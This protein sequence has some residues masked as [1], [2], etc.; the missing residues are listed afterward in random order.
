MR[1]TVTAECYS[2]GLWRNRGIRRMLAAT[3]VQ[4][5]LPG[6]G[7]A[8]AVWGANGRASAR[9]MRAAMR[10]G[11]PL[12]WLEDAPL[13]SVYPNDPLPIGVWVDHQR[14][15][16]DAS[17]P[18]DLED[19]L[20]AA[21]VPSEAAEHLCA[22]WP[23]YGLSKFNH[24]PEGV[25]PPEGPFVL[26]V[27]QMR[28][29]AAVAGAGATADSFARMHAAARAYAEKAGLPLL[30]RAH[31][32]GAGY[33]TAR[34]GDWICPMA[35]HP[36]H[37]LQQAAAVFTVSSQLGFEAILHGVRPHVFG[38]AWYAGWGLS[39]DQVPMPRRVARLTP[40]Q[41]VQAALI[42]HGRWYDPFEARPCDA[43]RAVVLLH[44]AG[45]AAQRTAAP[46][47]ATGISGW[48]RPAIRALLGRDVRFSP[49]SGR[50]PF[51]WATKP[52]APKGAVLIEDGPLRSRGLGAAL[53]PPC[54]I[55]LDRQGIHFDA[56][57]P[58]EFE[59]MVRAAETLPR[60]AH[61][62]ADALAQAIIA[63]GLSKY[64][65]PGRNPQLEGQVLLVPGQVVDDASLRLGGGLVRDNLALLSAARDL[66]PKAHIAY[67][68]HPDVVA[69]L[70]PGAVPDEAVLDHADMILVDTDL[71]ALWPHIERVVT[72][73][74]TLGFEALMR[75]IPVEC[76][77]WPFYAGWGQTVDHGPPL[78][79][80]RRH[81][82]RCTALL[83]TALID[84]PVYRDPVT[85]RRTAPEVIVSRLAAGEGGAQSLAQRLLS[86][87]QSALTPFGPI[88]RR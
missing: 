64:S 85:G 33:L 28:G 8:V 72:M 43:L 2:L 55:V 80:R 40:E 9:A 42:D 45:R 24:W 54:S 29:D 60:A 37:V 22:L 12:L 62:R 36:A 56:T 39:E 52:G 31:P 63:A 30:I 51:H 78:P 14:L 18:S 34:D 48:K 11:K 58:S 5:C 20:N 32:R 35:A 67:R 10:Q 76:L 41:L 82:V 88:W 81:P 71:S 66:H 1:S 19:R 69:G 83:H 74:S 46:I 44:G 23:A 6:Q 25:A 75:G 47:T 16:T 68:P 57:R 49:A 3:G 65:L 86:Q 7:E 4:L 79:E 87:G 61:L 84:Y 38:A 21:P 70:R 15:A 50:V 77:G 73:T 27:D 17:G 53:V 26:L 13:R 59:A